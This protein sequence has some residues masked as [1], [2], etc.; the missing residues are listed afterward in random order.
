[1]SLSL[2]LMASVAGYGQTPTV[3][4]IDLE[5]YRAQRIKAEADLRE[6]YERLGFPSPEERARRDAESAKAVAELSTKLRAARLERE[7]IEAARREQ[8]VQNTPIQVVQVPALDQGFYW[9]G[10]HWRVPRHGRR[11]WV[12]PGYFAGGAFWPTG[13]RT[14]PRPMIVQVRK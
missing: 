2:A 5:K 11:V 12:Q 8:S 14:R 6:N 1:M 4:N 3:T 10:G 7:R 9:M 13:S